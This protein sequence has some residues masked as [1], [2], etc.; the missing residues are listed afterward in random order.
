MN[1]SS[2]PS[3]ARIR[4]L[5]VAATAEDAAWVPWKAVRDASPMAQRMAL[6]RVARGT[7]NSSGSAVGAVGLGFGEELRWFAPV[8]D[9]SVRG[10]VI[11]YA[12]RVLMEGA[13][14]DVGDELRAFWQVPASS[15]VHEAAGEPSIDE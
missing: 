8:T 12:E 13:F 6:Q 10:S 4:I 1:K 7:G 5:V 11:A 9:A 14:P 2:A 3:P 15:A